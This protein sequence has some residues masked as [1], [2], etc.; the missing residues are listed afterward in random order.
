M[1]ETMEQR[2]G[3]NPS[4]TS[5]KDLIR[6]LLF[7][8]WFHIIVVVL[9]VYYKK[10]NHRGSNWSQLQY[11]QTPCPSSSTWWNS[12]WPHLQR[13]ALDCRSWVLICVVI[14]Y[15]IWSKYYLANIIAFIG[16]I[17]SINTSLW[18]CFCHKPRF[19]QFDG[20]FHM[21]TGLG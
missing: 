4:L 17:F 15:V 9:I 12:W 6:I 7:F 13:S 18:H 2:V 1:S 14:K 19:C 8:R 20:Y 5:L 3:H 11:L 16:A 21:I 10:E